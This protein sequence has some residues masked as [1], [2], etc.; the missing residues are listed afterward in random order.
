ML[1]RIL[2]VHD[3]NRKSQK[4]SDRRGSCPQ[5]TANRPPSGKPT[6]ALARWSGTFSCDPFAQ[7]M[8]EQFFI[9]PTVRA[10]FAFQKSAEFFWVRL[11]GLGDSFVRQRSFKFG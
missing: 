2:V 10:E 6:I 8:A 11:L 9:R 5:Q 3:K 4:D 7:L 1:G